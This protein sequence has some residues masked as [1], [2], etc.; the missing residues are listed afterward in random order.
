MDAS[1]GRE[2]QVLI[3]DDD[4]AVCALLARVLEPFAAITTVADAEAALEALAVRDFDAVVS[5]FMLPGMTGLEFARRVRS[6]PRTRDIPILMISGHEPSALRERA[7]RAGVDA[8]LDKPFTLLQVRGAISA[9]LLRTG[10][11]GSTQ[12]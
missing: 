12:A 11:V 6:E 5:D 4:R 1:A 10:E 2:K 9:L 7:C 8:F 3:A